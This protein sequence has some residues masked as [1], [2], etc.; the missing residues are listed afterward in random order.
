VIRRRH[1]RLPDDISL[2]GFDDVAW[3]GMV[4]PGITVIAQPSIEMGRRAA[5]LLLRRVEDPLCE[6]RVECLEPLLVIRGSTGP[7]RAA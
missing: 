2:V 7:P 5:R 4:D 1:L 3:M 6:P